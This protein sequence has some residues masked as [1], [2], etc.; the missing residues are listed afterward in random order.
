M[1]VLSLAANPGQSLGDENI[2]K[3][4][5]DALP[6]ENYRGQKIL[7]IVPDHTRTA[8]VGLLFK[9]IHRQIGE[10]TA[11]LD[12]MIALGTHPPMDEEAICKRLEISPAERREEYA[13]VQ[14][15]NHEW[16][17]RHALRE[18]GVIPASDI[19]E[20]SGGRFEMEL[21]VTINRR[22]FDYDQVIIVGPVF[23]HEV[24]GFSGGNKYLFPGV[25]G[26]ELLNFF[27]WLGAVISNPKIIGHK[28][29]AVRKVVDRAGG[30]V[31]VDKR[32]FAMV[33]RPD[34]SL[35]GLFFGT[36]ESAWDAAA[37]L[38]DKTHIVYKDRPFHTILSCAP[39]MYDDIWVGGKCM[40]KLEPVLADEGELIIYGPHINSISHT[41]E[42][43][44][45]EVGYHC[46]SWLLEHWEKYKNHPWGLLAHSS[47]VK[48]IGQVIDGAEKPRANVTLATGLSEEVC[49]QINLGYRNAE[50]IN[51]EDYA[52]REDEGILLVRKAGEMLYRLNDPPAWALP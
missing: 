5:G 34:K 15:H 9:N 41:H 38:S 37:D 10:A 47:H 18:I 1:N 23:P 27:H 30:M 28:W 46:S 45:Q 24:V 39:P 11:A 31:S 2:S 35:A 32:C 42:A 48:G 12:V 17:N 36:P 51:I 49:R 29:T 52:D 22:L 33:V 19:A 20:L 7:L 14:F 43:G 4:V 6:I 40:Y 8:P 21:P 44:I 3:L 26:P 50:S 25:S 13:K 16:N